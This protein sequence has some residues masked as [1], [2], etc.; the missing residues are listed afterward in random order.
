MSFTFIHNTQRPEPTLKKKSNFVCYHAV[1]VN[2][3][4]VVFNVLGV[5][6]DVFSV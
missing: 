5:V 3:S 4:L 1:C 6:H 2:V